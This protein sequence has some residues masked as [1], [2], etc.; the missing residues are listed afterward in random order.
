MSTYLVAFVVGDLKNISQETN[1]TL[2][3]FFHCI[4]NSAQGSGSLV[5]LLDSLSTG[6]RQRSL[7]CGL[8]Q[9]QRFYQV[10]CARIS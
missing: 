2:V 7:Y 10:V 6:D 4:I 3:C 9:L 8:D 5:V 1:R